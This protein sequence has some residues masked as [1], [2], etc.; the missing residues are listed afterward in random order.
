MGFNSAL[1][2]LNSILIILISYYLMKVDQINALSASLINF[3]HNVSSNRAYFGLRRSR[4]L[5][6]VGQY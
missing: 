6:L 2:G 1:K 4:H 5:G 3:M